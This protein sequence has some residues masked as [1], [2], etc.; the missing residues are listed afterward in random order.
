MYN[1]VGQTLVLQPDEEQ[2]FVGGESYHPMLPPG[3]GLFL[4]REPSVL[5][6][7]RDVA[8]RDVVLMARAVQQCADVIVTG[9]AGGRQA[10]GMHA[11]WVLG[12]APRVHPHLQ[13]QLHP[14]SCPGASPR[15]PAA[16]Y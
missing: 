11:A 10:P 12:A 9:E 6:S 14:S 16:R 5:H 3:P 15:C 2:V 7:V 13:H 8:R 1:F 4:V